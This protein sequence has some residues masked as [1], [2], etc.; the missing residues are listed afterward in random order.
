MGDSTQSIQKCLEK[1]LS[2]RFSGLVEFGDSFECHFDES[3][4]VKRTVLP[5]KAKY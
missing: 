5:K 2:V 3:C 4:S 1:D